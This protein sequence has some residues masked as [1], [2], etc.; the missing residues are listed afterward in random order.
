MLNIMLLVGL[1]GFVLLLMAA[2]ALLLLMRPSSGQQPAPVTAHAIPAP[3]P[4]PA[5]PL[6][7]SLRDRELD[8]DAAAIA[9]E[10]RRARHERYL[11]SLRDDAAAYFGPPAAGKKAQG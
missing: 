11:A 2:A 6:R 7:Y 10:F 8:E 1:G 3:A 4:Q 5:E 9:N